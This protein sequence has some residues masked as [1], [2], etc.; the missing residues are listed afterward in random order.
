M[1]RHELE[2]NR[3]IGFS[4]K[5]TSYFTSCTFYPSS[6]KNTVIGTHCNWQEYIKCHQCLGTERKIENHCIKARLQWDKK[7]KM[8]VSSKVEA[9]FSSYFWIKHNRSESLE[10]WDKVTFPIVDYIIFVYFFRVSS[11]LPTVLE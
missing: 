9:E 8:R 4:L 6:L 1:P 3:H 2:N 5:Y 11:L 7:R 10:E